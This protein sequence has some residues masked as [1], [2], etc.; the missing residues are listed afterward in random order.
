[1]SK[2][3]EVGQISEDDRLEAVAL[4]ESHN[5]PA[6]DVYR[7]EVDEDKMTVFR[8]QTPRALRGND[9]AVR[10]PVEISL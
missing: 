5:M 3:Y 7:L 8:Y 9:V 10:P 2:V 4:L 1:M 6:D